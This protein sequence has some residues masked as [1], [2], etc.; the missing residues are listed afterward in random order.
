ME[1]RCCWTFGRS[2]HC[3]NPTFKSISRLSQFCG[4]CNVP[5]LHLFGKKCL[6]SSIEKKP[7]SL[8]PYRTGRLELG[9]QD[10][11]KKGSIRF[12]DPKDDILYVMSVEFWEFAYFS[13]F[14]LFPR[15]KWLSGT[16]YEEIWMLPIIH[17]E[18]VMRRS[19]CGKWLFIC[20]EGDVFFVS[21]AFVLGEILMDPVGKDVK[22]AVC[23]KLKLN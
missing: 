9:L 8:W 19:L 17:I 5:S 15:N 12:S 14:F 10:E 18:C 22:E 4:S 23:G 21:L 6:S 11:T 13:I 16:E 3:S 1:S 2:F 20:V 7:S